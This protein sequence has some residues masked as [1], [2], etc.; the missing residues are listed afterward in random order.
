VL[1]TGLSIHFIH[2]VFQFAAIPFSPLT[3]CEGLKGSLAKFGWSAGSVCFANVPYSE[4]K[5]FPFILKYSQTAFENSVI[6]VLL[7]LLSKQLK[8]K[9][10]IKFR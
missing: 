2:F 10:T 6:I 3:E 8:Q 4:G 5:V 1:P 7:Y 9:S